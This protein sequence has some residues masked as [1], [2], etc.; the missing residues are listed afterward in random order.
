MIDNVIHYVSLAKNIHALRRNSWL[1]RS[2]LEKI[3]QKKLRA[4][5]KHAYYNVPFYHSLFDSVGVKP[6]DIKTVEDMYKIPVTTKSQIQHS[7]EEIIA[8]DINLNNCIKRKTSGSSGI[9]LNI[10]FLK[11]DTYMF[12]GTDLRSKTENG[13]DLLSDTTLHV[14]APHN[15]PKGKRWFQYLGIMKSV[16]ISVFD[17]INTQISILQKTHPNVISGYPMSLKLL[18]MAVQQKGIEGLNPRLCFCSSELLDKKSREFINSVFGTE[19][20]DRYS[21]METGCMAWECSEHAG[22]HMNID[23]LVMEFIKDGERV[24]AGER[25]EVVITNLHSYAL[26]LIRYK[27]GDIAITMAEEQCPCGRGLPLMKLIEGRTGDFVK[28]PDGGVFP[29]GIIALTMRSIPGIAHFRITQHKEDK[30]TVELVEGKDFSEETIYQ[31]ITEFK[32]V[33]GDNIYIEPKIVKE[34]AKDKS[35]KLR[36]VTSKVKVF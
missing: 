11:T 2:E 34:I 20:I 27:I 22:Y 23:T 10:I 16:H 13:L 5:I 28:V 30:F 19:V 32:K 17:D 3:Q 15:I 18:A 33:L 9:P 8:R 6:G 25:G 4:I 14:T 31:I 29:P 12:E 24:S 7:G 21:A 26:P 36:S 35:G 1:K